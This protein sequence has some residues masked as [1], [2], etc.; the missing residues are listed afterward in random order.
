MEALELPN[1]QDAYS[2]EPSTTTVHANKVQT[3]YQSGFEDFSTSPPGHLLRRYSR[4]SDTSSLPPPKR[5]KNIDIHKTK[6]SKPLS[7]QLRPPL[8]K[9]FLNASLRTYPVC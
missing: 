5:R 6:G 9:S 2:R 4:V 7:K 8:N 1:I 3:K